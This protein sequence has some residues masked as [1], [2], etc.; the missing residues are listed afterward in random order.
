MKNS[1]S[2][3]I[4]YLFSFFK[5]LQFFGAV[6]VPFYLHRIGLDYTRMFILEAVFSF[7]MIVFEIPTGVVADRWGRKISLFFGSCFFGAGFLMFGIFSSYSILVI[8]EI[9]CAFGMTLLS[10]ADRAIIYEILKDNSEESRAAVIMARYDAFGTAGLLLAFPAGSLLA[11]SDLLPYKTALG[12]VFVAT[13]ISVFISGFIVLFV[14]EGAYEKSSVNAFRQG[15]N[16]FMSIIRIPQLRIFSLNFALISSM[17]F[18]MFWFYQ[19]LLLENGFPL[20]WQGFIASGFNL[21]AMLLLLFMPAA[22]RRIGIKNTLFL[23]S[24]IPGIL[25]LLLSFIPGLIMAIIAIFG[26]TNLKIFRAPV[27]NALINDQIESSDRATVLSG[28]SMIERFSTTLLYPVAGLLTDV[29]LR[30]TF[31]IIGIIT[32]IISLMLRIEENSLKT[33]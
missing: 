30:M 32:V 17:T 6:A 8:A 28:V 23:T 18:F 14:K 33:V 1:K 11:G 4:L 24:F 25:Y 22:D 16:G 5:N 29:S 27:L 21:S 31:L 7:S 3:I 15:L 20:T 9:I 13:A 12:L 10:G 2:I 19:S 26:V